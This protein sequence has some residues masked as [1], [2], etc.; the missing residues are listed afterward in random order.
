LQK[1]CGAE[2]KDI[3]CKREEDMSEQSVITVDLRL[4]EKEAAL[5]A[6]AVEWLV[7]ELGYPPEDVSRSYRDS[8]SFFLKNP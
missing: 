2:N 8:F 7:H 5:L 6:C 3:S 1:Y 4:D